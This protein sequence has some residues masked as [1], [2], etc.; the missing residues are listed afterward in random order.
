MTTISVTLVWILA[1]INVLLLLL[2]GGSVFNY[3]RNRRRDTAA[4]ASLVSTI[5]EREPQQLETLRASLV[6]EY[7]QDEGQA[8]DTAKQ[9]M[10]LKKKFYKTIITIYIDKHREAFKAL[11][12]HLD[13]LIM[14]YRRQMP[15]VDEAPPQP[16]EETD[17]EPQPA[18]GLAE[19]T[20][21]L[22]ADVQQLKRQN[23]Q[24][25]SDLEQTKR[26]LE[27]TI[28]E[29]VSA[30]S[31]GAELGKAKLE[32]ELEKLQENK[33]KG[34]LEEENEAAQALSGAG[35]V[36]QDGLEREDTEIVMTAADVPA[37]REAIDE[38][39]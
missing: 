28:T 34:L 6:S 1:E 13:D 37:E 3:L 10:R 16:A 15:I 25:K 36:P 4:V 24:L 33:H 8:A 7:G 30:Y 27:S 22:S 29:Y 21:S 18:E 11:D 26:E 9:L 19:M 35:G 5:K 20:D 32:S 14:S 2:L 39:I 31:G 23:E 12:Q 17:P 38:K